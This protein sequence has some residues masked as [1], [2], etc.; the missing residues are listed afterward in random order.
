M[1]EL[2]LLIL[3]CAAWILL[4]NFAVIFVNPVEQILT[5]VLAAMETAVITVTTLS[6][7]TTAR[8][9]PDIT[10]STTSTVV[11]KLFT[12]FIY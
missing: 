10:L 3:S 1:C 9:R 4:F 2:L 12:A 5:N 6:A 8:V 11:V 7:A